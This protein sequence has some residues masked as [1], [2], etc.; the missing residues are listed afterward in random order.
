MLYDKIEG[1]MA[2]TFEVIEMMLA[3]T[4]MQQGVLVDFGMLCLGTFELYCVLNFH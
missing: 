1:L 4:Q 2:R 3:G